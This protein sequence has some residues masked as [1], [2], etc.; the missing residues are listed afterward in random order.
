MS[1]SKGAS[2][3]SATQYPNPRTAPLMHHAIEVD[4]D[5]LALF[6]MHL[7][8]TFG[9]LVFPQHVVTTSSNQVSMEAVLLHTAAIARHYGSQDPLT[10][11]NRSP[12]PLMLLTV[13]TLMTSKPTGSGGF[14]PPGMMSKLIRLGYTSMSPS[15]CSQHR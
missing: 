2:I 3:Q 8:R 7:A 5:P 10:L 13:L 14:P 9:M 12:P 1:P 11:E 6:R 15:T 4:H